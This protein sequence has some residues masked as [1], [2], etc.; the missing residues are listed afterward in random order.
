MRTVNISDLKAQLSS[1]IRFVRDGEEVLVCD[2]NKPVARIVPV[3]SEDPS[4]REQ[5][6]VARGVLAPPLR[7]RPVG[8]LPKPPGGVSNDAIGKIWR[9]EREGR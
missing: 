5:R 4:G 3:R 9:E 6:L 8:S 1:H 2:R 7:R